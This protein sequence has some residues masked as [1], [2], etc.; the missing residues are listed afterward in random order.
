MRSPRVAQLG[1]IFGSHQQVDD[2]RRDDNMK[3]ER[4]RKTLREQRR[5]PSFSLHRQVLR[6]EGLGGHQQNLTSLVLGH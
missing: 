2:Q 5:R 6:N 1:D 4:V 3:G